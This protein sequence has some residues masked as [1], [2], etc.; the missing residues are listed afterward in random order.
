MTGF[1]FAFLATLIVGTGAR[2]QLLIAN[3]S[4]R[5]GQRPALLV[6]ALTTS[7]VT[8]AIAALAAAK[9]MPLLPG[10]ARFFLAAVAL[11]LGGGE[12][13]LLG[14]AR[15]PDEPTQSLGATAIVLSA[16]QLTDAARF[17]ILAI[18]AAT[19][20]PVSAGLGGAVGG[21]IV[22]AAGWLGGRDLLRLRLGLMRR[23][24]G[25]V[26][27]A[28]AAVLMARATGRL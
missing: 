6:I 14:A 22:V 10:D 11:A 7:A 2:D 12:M 24:A 17:L 20:A 15:Q 16:H 1:M 19:Q 5:V 21:G 4:A 13:L 18:A 26:L 27:L 23:V 28:L 3:L 9:L 8:A 25:G